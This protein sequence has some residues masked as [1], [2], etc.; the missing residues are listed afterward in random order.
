VAAERLK[1]HSVFH[2][3]EQCGPVATRIPSQFSAPFTALST[4][5]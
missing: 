3:S 4:F 2:R 1:S 5:R